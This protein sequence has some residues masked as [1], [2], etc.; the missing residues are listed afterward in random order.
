VIGLLQ[1]RQQRLDSRQVIRARFRQRH[2]SRGARQQGRAHLALEIGG[3]ARRGGLGKAKLAP[4]P[5]EAS[6]V[7]NTGEKA[8]GEE[9]VAHPVSEYILLA[10]GGYPSQAE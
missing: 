3:D 9:T 10:A 5:G 6:Q 7:G 1:R 2:G 4:T 8:Q